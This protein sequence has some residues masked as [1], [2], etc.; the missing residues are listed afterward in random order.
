M[1]HKT[2]ATRKILTPNKKKIKVHN[3]QKQ[4]KEQLT[5]L[6]KQE[7]IKKNATNNHDQHIDINSFNSHVRKRNKNQTKKR[8]RRSNKQEASKI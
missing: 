8:K 1:L 4:L 2:T 5:L 6:L 3:Q 7:P